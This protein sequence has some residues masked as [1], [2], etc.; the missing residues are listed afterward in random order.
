MA[1]PNSNR[2]ELSGQQKF[3]R[4]VPCLRDQPVPN[5]SIATR[6]LTLT[7]DEKPSG[8]ENAEFERTIPRWI[9]SSPQC[10][11]HLNPKRC[12]KLR[13]I[14]PHVTFPRRLDAD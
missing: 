11:I 7:N 9:K 5:H 2:D 4:N 6:K 13:C 12:G 3:R 10:S 8:P 14:R 1:A